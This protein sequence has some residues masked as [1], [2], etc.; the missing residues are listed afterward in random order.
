MNEEIKKLQ[1]RK[2]K[3]I[4]AI[5]FTKQKKKQVFETVQKLASKLGSKLITR[6]QYEEE[7]KRALR[8]RTAEQWIKY[9]DD[10]VDY[11]NYQIKLCD[12][13]IKQ[14]KFSRLKETARKR[15]VP[16]LK[17]SIVIV[18]VA[19][20]FSLIF[21]LRPVG[22][23]VFEKVGE[24]VSTTI[25]QLTEKPPE[26]LTEILIPE[27]YQEP[28]VPVI[29]ED[30][31]VLIKEESLTQYPAVIGNNVKWKKQFKVDGI[32]GF[33]VELPKDSENIKVKII[34]NGKE[35]D[36]TEIA[37]I[38]KKRSFFIFEKGVEVE[39]KEKAVAGITGAVIS[40]INLNLVLFEIIYETPAPEISELKAERAIKK[41]LIKGPDD[42]HYK[43]ILSFT[44]LPREFGEN[45][46]G[47]LKLYEIKDGQRI[48]VEVLYYDTDENGLYDYAEWIIPELSEA[49]YEFVIEITKAEHLDFERNFISDIYNEVYQLDGI[50]SEEIND[51]EYVRVTFKQKLDNTRDIT[52]YLRVINGEPRIEVYEA[53][54]TE[55]IAEFTSLI[56]NTYN[57]VYLTNLP[58]DYSQ[59]VFDLRIVSGIIE[60][61]H[62]I[63]PSGPP[64]LSFVPPTPNHED[65]LTVDNFFVNVSSSDE[66]QHYTFLDFNKDVLLWMRMDEVNQTGVG[67]KVYDNSS[68]GQHGIAFGDAVQ[69]TTGK[70]GKGFSFINPTST[71]ADYI[72]ITNIPGFGER[73]TVAGWIN[74]NDL[75][76][77]RVLIA[78]DKE[79]HLWA[80][81]NKK[82]TKFSAGIFNPV[83]YWGEILGTTEL[84]TGVWYHVVLS[85]DGSNFKLYV[86][87]VQ[88]GL[89]MQYYLVDSTDPIIIGAQ[90]G[91][92]N[93]THSG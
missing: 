21:I 71:P 47:R 28:K 16:A 18:A 64:N 19:L 84:S 82:G 86:N 8:S 38:N 4:E 50:W 33:N 75:S 93:M 31:N 14:E 42:V 78:A 7:L 63:D 87:G 51:G 29:L 37:D 90:K 41:V 1:E 24:K 57:K 6:R 89:T 45:E 66:N 25:N 62:I 27:S 59:D 34:E 20:I 72:N 56:N 67:A 22:M 69:S 58:E 3:L 2:K 60:I 91:I 26:A 77:D 83:N 79:F 55:K 11:Y 52:I 40:D 12:K 39:I 5:D 30:K 36:I 88:E 68:Y 48:L 35:R 15:A 80:L 76:K 32:T 46:I 43:N 53:N 23:N 74:F 65:V 9:Y 17:I 54:G 81:Y 49:V 70:F 92:V 73:M 85:Y 10:Y 61:E 44:E 13:L